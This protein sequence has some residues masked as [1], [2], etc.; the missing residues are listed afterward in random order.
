[1]LT[2]VQIYMQTNY[3]QLQIRSM[4]LIRSMMQIRS[5]MLMLKTGV[6]RATTTT[7]TIFKWRLL[8][9]YLLIM[10]P[11]T[12]NHNAC[13]PLENYNPRHTNHKM[14]SGNIKEHVS[15]YINIQ[16]NK[17]ILGT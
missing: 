6:Y 16:L 7:T 17:F 15:Q 3:I 4:M 5:M 12:F 10:W 11:T 14:H 13:C 9:N 8:C 1:M 2:H